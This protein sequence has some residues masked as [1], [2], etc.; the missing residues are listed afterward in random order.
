MLCRPKSRPSR[1]ANEGHREEQ[2]HSQGRRAGDRE[3]LR[4]LGQSRGRG[5]ESSLEPSGM[6]NESKA[7]GQ[8]SP[9]RESGIGEVMGP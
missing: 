7:G 6:I 3:G 4:K 9:K 1:F 8:P 5:V 2:R